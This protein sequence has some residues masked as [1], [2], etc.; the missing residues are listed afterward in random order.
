MIRQQEYLPF[1]FLTG[2][3]VLSLVTRADT[4][5]VTTDGAHL[6][7]CND[8]SY[9]QNLRNNL[10]PDDVELVRVYPREKGG[11]ILAETLPSD[12]DFEVVVEAEAGQTIL[13]SGGVYSIQIVVRDLTD[14]TVVYEDKLEGHF[15]R[16]PWDEQTLSHAFP[17][18]AQGP[19]KEYHVYE[20][21]ASLSARTTN[22]DVS[23]AKSPMFMIF[24]P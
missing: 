16:E 14:F 23:F 4:C 9:Q 20:A 10:A 7:P 13:G 1:F 6:F 3:L 15:M 24:R 22:P 11:L 17:I 8:V 12:T 19:A 5:L 18:R 2:V 21:L